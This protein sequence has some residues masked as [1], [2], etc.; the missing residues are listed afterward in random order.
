[1]KQETAILS[2]PALDWK[3]QILVAKME[4]EIWTMNKTDSNSLPQPK[5]TCRV[6][7]PSAEFVGKQGLSYGPGISAESAGAHAIHLQVVTIPAGGRAKAHRHSGHET[8]IYI[9]SGESGMWYGERLEEHLSAKS[10]DFVYIPA[11]MPHLPY[12]LSDTEN[13]VAVIARTDPNEQES[14]LLLPELDHIHPS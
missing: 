4:N 2:N 11:D 7:G 3:R 9:L 8:G 14:V 12:N 6:V 13:C 10:G 1:M 5:V